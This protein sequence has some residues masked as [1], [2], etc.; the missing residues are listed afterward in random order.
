MK[1]KMQVPIDP[2]L[3]AWPA[4]KP[5]LFGSK[6]DDCGN[7]AFPQANSC[8][9]CGGTSVEKFEL[10]T[11]GTLWTWTYQ[12]FRPKGLKDYREPEAFRPYYLGYVELPGQ[13]VLETRLLIDDPSR[14][15][16]GMPMELDI[17]KFRDE[18]D[19]TETMTYV[20]KPANA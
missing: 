3:F 17:I 2:E 8:P 14:I 16:I 20:F 15:Q 19:G 9:K 5:N 4:P 11:K 13:V 12:E 18:P 7:I 1:G 10:N 6:C